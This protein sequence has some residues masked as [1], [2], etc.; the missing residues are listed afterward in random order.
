MV[1]DLSVYERTMALFNGLS[2][3]QARR[4]IRVS[5]L[6]GLSG[7]VEDLSGRINEQAS[8]STFSLHGVLSECVGLAYP[9]FKPASSES[10]TT[11]LNRSLFELRPDSLPANLI[12]TDTRDSPWTIET[13]TLSSQ[14]Q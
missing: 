1:L 14:Q 8:L 11:W 10:I 12:R 5:S 7:H 13:L 4:N 9:L 6:V 3:M 2:P